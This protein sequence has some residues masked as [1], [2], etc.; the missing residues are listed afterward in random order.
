MALKHDVTLL[1]RLLA[2]PFY[3]TIRMKI[4]LC[5]PLPLVVMLEIQFFRFVDVDNVAISK[6]TKMVYHL[7]YFLEVLPIKNIN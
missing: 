5:D 2:C 6:L 7:S 3:L 4:I 1:N